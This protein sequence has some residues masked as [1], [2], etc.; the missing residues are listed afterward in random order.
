LVAAFAESGN[1]STWVRILQRADKLSVETTTSDAWG[2]QP[3]IRRRSIDAALAAQV[4][5]RLAE[6]LARGALV[7]GTDEVQV[8]GISYLYTPDG[9]TCATVP[10][11]RNTQAKI[12]E[13]LFFTLAETGAARDARTWFWLEQLDQQPATLSTSLAGMTDKQAVIGA[14]SSWK[15]AGTEP[16]TIVSHRATAG[17]LD[18]SVLI[19]GELANNLGTAR[20]RPDVIA[21]FYDANGA[22]LATEDG[23]VEFSRLPAGVRSPF[24]VRTKHKNAASYTLRIV[25]G[26]AVWL[27]P[28]SLRITQ[29]EARQ[30]DEDLIVRGSVR[31]DGKRVEDDV[32]IYVL[33][34]DH[35]GHLLDNE[36]E[37]IDAPLRPG[38]SAGFEVSVERPPGYHHY[39]VV[40]NPEYREQRE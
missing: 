14:G 24:F 20:K 3:K 22:V 23:L 36:S 39:E 28:P 11:D 10:W 30:V 8:D 38:T 37:G 15:R 5:A 13:Q 29:R 6:D 2:N 33:V 9:K 35:A 16:M 25:P 12:W 26:D 4:S 1:Y 27:R 18:G 21:T 31:N 32:E 7:E 17:F 19:E 40:V 34:Y